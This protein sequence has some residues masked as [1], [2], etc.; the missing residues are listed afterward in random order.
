MSAH[1]YN[2]CDNTY[3]RIRILRIGTRNAIRAGKHHM[4]TTG[5]HWPYMS[6]SPSSSYFTRSKSSNGG[7]L[8][9]LSHL[10]CT[11]QSADIDMATQRNKRHGNKRPQQKPRALWQDTKSYK[12]LCGL[13]GAQINATAAH[14]VPSLLAC[15]SRARGVHVSSA[16]PARQLQNRSPRQTA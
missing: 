7:T 10:T 12:L 16:L 15:D 2:T 5:K 13:L 8:R 6:S 9:V 1:A 14:Y 3:T 4:I 11:R